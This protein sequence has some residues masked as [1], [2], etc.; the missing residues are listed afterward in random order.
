MDRDRDSVSH[1]MLGTLARFHTPRSSWCDVLA[2]V[3]PAPK[4]PRSRHRPEVKGGLARSQTHQCHDVVGQVSGKVW[5]NKTGQASQC[6][7]SVVLAGA[8]QVLQR[9][10]GGSAG[11][12][13]VHLPA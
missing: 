2:S 1:F 12:L 7:A 3:F 4:Q 10:G 6:N 11:A 8:A 13:T 9:E 5:G